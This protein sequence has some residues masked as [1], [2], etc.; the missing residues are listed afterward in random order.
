VASAALFTDYILPVLVIILMEKFTGGAWIICL[1][2]PLL[3]AISGKIKAPYNAVANA[4]TLE[5]ARR[6]LPAS[7][8]LELIQA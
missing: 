8:C 5:K 1:L 6:D 2:I 4:L 3:V 7:G